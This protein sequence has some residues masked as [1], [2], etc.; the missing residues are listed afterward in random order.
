MPTW[1]RR[2]GRALAVVFVLVGLFVAKDRLIPVSQ[3]YRFAAD[4][5][6]ARSRIYEDLGHVPMEEDG[7]RTVADVQE[8]IR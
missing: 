3:S 4:I 2:L 8:F 1:L 5:P 7:T 6:G